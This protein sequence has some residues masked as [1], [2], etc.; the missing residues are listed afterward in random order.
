MFSNDELTRYDRQIRIDKI[1]E[2][3]QLKLKKSSVLIMGAG[4]L[5]SPVS[6]YLAS[7]GI[8]R[9]GLVDGDKV[10]LTNLNRQILYDTND[11]G[12]KKAPLAK[13]KLQD[14][15]PNVTVEAY[16]IWLTDS[17]IAKNI[18]LKYDAVIDATDN[19]ET[20]YFINRTCVYLNKPLFIG[21]VGRFVG[22]V[23]D[24][25]PHKTAC[26]NCLFPEKEKDVVK[27]MTERNLSEGIIGTLVGTIGTIVATEFIKF[28]LDIGSN[29]FNRL[30]LY[31]LLNNEFS[32]INLEKN[33]K[34]SVCGD[35]K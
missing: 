19:F 35:T 7:A 3:G 27:L 23:M 12:K 16:P 22:Q 17:E 4:G 20:R 28:T 21:A 31:D 33:P 14:L 9:I 26:F 5:A 30:L 24:V 25:L 29:L 10:S 1:G 15:N 32:I 13:E 6:M 8:G 18:F 2:E 11:V 34:C